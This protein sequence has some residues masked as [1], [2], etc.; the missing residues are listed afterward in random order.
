M[1][2][3]RADL[4]YLLILGAIFILEFVL[5]GLRP[6]DRHTWLLENALV[7]VFLIA[8]ASTFKKI[9][10]SRVSYTLIFLFLSLHEVGAPRASA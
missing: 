4:R 6:H 9:P 2:P 1:T 10:F 8:L 3:R 5:L 7:V